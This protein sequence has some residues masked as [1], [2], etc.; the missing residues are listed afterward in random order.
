M[1]HSLLVDVSAD[2]QVS[3]SVWRDGELPDRVGEP[4]EL[5]WP[6]DD[7]A[8][9]DLRWYLE[10]Y[11]PAPYAVYEERG[12]RVE[13]SLP[14]WGEAVFGSVFGA[15]AARDAYVAARAG[16]DALELVVRSPSPRWLGMPWELLRVLMVISRPAGAKDVGYRMVARPLLRRLEAVRGEVDLVVLR[17]AARRAETGTRVDGQMR[18]PV[19]RVPAPVH[20]PWPSA[21]CQAHRCRWNGGA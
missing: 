3:L 18:R 8:L 16:G 19:R 14:A 7:E 4:V 1:T 6:L 17:R 15:G 5:A 11:L 10:D 12:S 21:P 9:E 2:G 20:W 13:E